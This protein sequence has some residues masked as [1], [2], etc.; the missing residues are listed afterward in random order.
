MRLGAST[1]AYL[2]AS[3]HFAVFGVGPLMMNIVPKK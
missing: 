1:F 2:K 3:S